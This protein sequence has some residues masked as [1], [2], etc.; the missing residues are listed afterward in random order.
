M[1]WHICV[2]CKQVVTT[3]NQMS[4]WRQMPQ[5]CYFLFISFSF[6]AL[7][8]TDFLFFQIWKANQVVTQGTTKQASLILIRTKIALQ[9]LISREIISEIWAKVVLFQKRFY[10]KKSSHTIISWWSLKRSKKNRKAVRLYVVPSRSTHISGHI[11]VDKF[12]LATDEEFG[13]LLP[14]GARKKI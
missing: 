6:T 13:L 8:P 10:C 9:W 3:Q 7:D 1:V 11:L 12:Y 5:A 14:W 4:W 2:G